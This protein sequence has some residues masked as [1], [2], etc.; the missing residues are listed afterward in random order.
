MSH[1]IMIL[2]KELFGDE[3][4]ITHDNKRVIIKKT[5][6]DDILIILNVMIS[7][8]KTKLLDPK[9]PPLHS[10]RVS[11]FVARI[12]LGRILNK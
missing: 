10:G 8:R 7:S 2:A 4:R 3:M 11:T 6:Y 9:S 1:K 5:L 12:I